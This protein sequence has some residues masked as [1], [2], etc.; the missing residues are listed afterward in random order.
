MGEEGLVE[1]SKALVQVANLGVDLS[2]ARR[3]LAE[4]GQRLLATQK[5]PG[6]LIP[7]EPSN[8]SEIEAKRFRP[9]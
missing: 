8:R 6:L 7:G 5:G 9:A 1:P 3:D 4:R 2:D